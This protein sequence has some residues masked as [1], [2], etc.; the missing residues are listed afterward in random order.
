MK[1]L[2]VGALD[3]GV[4]TEPCSASPPSG[5]AFASSVSLS[6]GPRGRDRTTQAS[7]ARD[8][9]GKLSQGKARQ[10]RQVKPRWRLPGDG[11]EPD[12]ALW[13]TLDE[14][15]HFSGRA[16]L[17]KS[18]IKCSIFRSRSSFSFTRNRDVCEIVAVAGE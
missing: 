16:A 8:C 15:F 2:L 1:T 3:R 17:A 7:T 13:A 9:Q 6:A 14:V 10:V 5:E 4:F 18:L 12:L 11:A